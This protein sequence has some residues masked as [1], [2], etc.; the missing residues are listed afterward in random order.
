MDL[1]D[2]RILLVG[3]K[4]RRVGDPALDLAPIGG[5]FPGDAF[6][7]REVTAAENVGVKIGQL[8]PA[9]AIA[10]AD[11]GEVIGAG[12]RRRPAAVVRGAERAGGVGTA[13]GRA[14]DGVGDAVKRAVQAGAG[15]HGQ[16]DIVKAHP[17]RIVAIPGDL[18]DAAIKI[19]QKLARLA[20]VSA[21]HIKIGVDIGLI[22]LFFAQIGQGRAVGRQAGIGFCAR[23]NR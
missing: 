7:F 1:Q 22:A 3:V 17:E 23:E 19:G 13:K 15:E 10:G 12:Q 16:A 18:I 4:A 11:I 14:A 21:H 6:D 9:A 2:H 20:A 8:A 5:A